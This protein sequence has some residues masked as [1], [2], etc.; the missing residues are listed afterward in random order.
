MSVSDSLAVLIRRGNAAVL[1]WRELDSIA[2]DI[3]DRLEAT[4][5]QPDTPRTFADEW[6]RRTEFGVAAK[7]RSR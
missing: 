4:M 3:R 6:F 7:K 5:A 1:R 2:R